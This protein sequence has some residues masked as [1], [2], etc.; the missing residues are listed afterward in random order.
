MLEQIDLEKEIADK[1]YKADRSD[2]YRIGSIKGN[3]K[4]RHY[5]MELT[6]E[7]IKEFLHKQCYYCGELNANGI[8]RLDSTKHYTKDNCVPC[9]FICNR[10]KNKYS[11]NVFMDKIEKIYKKFYIEGS[12]TISKESTSQANGDGNGELL[13]AA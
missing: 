5:N 10:M 9:C 13:T 7:E 6:D 8:D 2:R 1:K 11:F 12:T 4:N 3:A